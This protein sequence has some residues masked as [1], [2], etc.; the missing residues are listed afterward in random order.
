MKMFNLLFRSAIKEEKSFKVTV[1]KKRG[2]LK[3]TL[4]SSV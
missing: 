1:I 4:W 3:R 2:C